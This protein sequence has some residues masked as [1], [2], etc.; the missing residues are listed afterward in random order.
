[1]N[2]DPNLGIPRACMNLHYLASYSCS[3]ELLHGETEVEVR[4]EYRWEC[5]RAVSFDGDNA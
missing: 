1:M 2:L 5:F 3:R 4:D